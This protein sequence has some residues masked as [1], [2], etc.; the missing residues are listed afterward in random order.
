[1]S[2]VPLLTAKDTKIKKV[3]N[4]TNQSL[5]KREDIGNYLE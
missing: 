3:F 4:V 2:L 5:F 1:M